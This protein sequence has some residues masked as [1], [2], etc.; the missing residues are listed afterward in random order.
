MYVWPYRLSFW[1]FRLLLEKIYQIS[2]CQ[3]NCKKIR[4]YVNSLEQS[5]Y[6]KI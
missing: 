5:E 2:K 1:F 3:F 6:N 4:D